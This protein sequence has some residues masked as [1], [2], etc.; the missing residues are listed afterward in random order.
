MGE[1]ATVT[2]GSTS[3]GVGEGVGGTVVGVEV[4]GTDVGVG[5]GGAGRV[6]FGLAQAVRIISKITRMG[7]G[8]FIYI[9]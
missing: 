3:V 9:L 5:D 1:G 8:A 7:K 4:D 6:S 2:V